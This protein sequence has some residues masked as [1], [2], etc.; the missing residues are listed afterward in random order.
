MTG[1]LGMSVLLGI[2]LG[3]GLSVVLARV[4]WMRRPSFTDRIE[5][6]LRA[7]TAQSRLLQRQTEAPTLFGPLERIARV[8]L[9]DAS[10]RFND[11][12]GRNAVLDAKLQRAGRTQTA[13]EFRAEQVMAAAVGVVLG[14]ML[15]IAVSQFAGF[16][17]FVLVVIV[18]TCGL[19]GV[20][21]RD[22]LL[23][24]AI[25][26]R[27]ARIVVEFPALA[28]LMSLAV[29]AGESASAA[30]SR[31]AFAS[32]GELAK[33]FRRVLAQQKSGSSLSEALEALTQRVQLS[34]IS[35]FADGLS[36]AVERGT[37]L[38]DVLRA[39]AA[40]ARDLAKRSLMESSGRK[41]IAMMIP[42]VFGVLPVTILFA[43]FPGFALL[44]L[45][46]ES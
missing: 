43:A 19:L 34:A 29:S 20:I 1:Q 5:P 41:E 33:E 39:Q 28:E 2:L 18:L 22:Q 44:T 36:V 42:L 14:V 26:R 15:G 12:S 3:A 40:D 27:E 24:H 46:I 10:R 31:V 45:T 17:L 23:I 6:Q 21:I 13:L 7:A 30:L 9:K 16:N 4:P 32:S 8:V 37:P 38:A 11:V 25:K 35:R